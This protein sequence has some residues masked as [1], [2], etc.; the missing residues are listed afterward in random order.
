[1]FKPPP[2][3]PY[4]SYLHQALKNDIQY[5]ASSKNSFLGGDIKC[6]PNG[7]VLPNR[8]IVTGIIL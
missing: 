8:T 6:F 1:M 4:N 7:N 2:E 3:P 5:F